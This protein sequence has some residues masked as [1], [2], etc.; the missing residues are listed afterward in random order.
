MRNYLLHSLKARPSD[1]KQLRVGGSEVN[2]RIT[3]RVQA[4]N[5][6]T[7]GITTLRAMGATIIS[8]TR[9][10]NEHARTHSVRKLDIHTPVYIYIWIYTHV[11]ENVYIYICVC[12]HIYIYIDIHMPPCVCMRI[13]IYM[14]TVGTWILGAGEARA[15]S[16]PTDMDGGIFAP[17]TCIS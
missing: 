14:W 16:P 6:C 3:P 15:K 10:N 8:T 9:N 7:V 11:C 17:L 1:K 13:N 12:V 4:W 5:V 2:H